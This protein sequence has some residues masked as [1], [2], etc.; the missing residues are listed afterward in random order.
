[1][2]NTYSL[3]ND[4]E[5]FLSPHFKVK[6]FACKDGSDE[7]IV[8]NELI[9]VLEKIRSRFA[10]P[11]FIVNGYKSLEYD[12]KSGGSG[13]GYHTKG[14][15]ADILISDVSP[16]AIALYAQSILKDIGGIGCL[17][18]DGGYVHID[19]RM[20][21]W[22]AVKAYGNR[23]YEK[24]NGN[25]F[26]TVKTGSKG[27]SVIILQRMLNQKGY[28]SGKIREYFDMATCYSVKSYQK[29]NDLTDD[30]ICGSETWLSLIE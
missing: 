3:K 29:A 18:F 13:M 25:L 4:G 28:Y 22:R 9:S 26:P 16:A 2:I 20:H 11:I 10:E 24:V 27:Q 23:E 12:K 30:G 1:M 7:V 17:C 5:F 14:M 8:S 15:A 21:N 6:E 19:V